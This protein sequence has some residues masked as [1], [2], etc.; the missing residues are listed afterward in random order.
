MV[1]AAA[2]EMIVQCDDGQHLQLT[3][4]DTER[5]GLL[6]DLPA[7]ENLKSSGP[8]PLPFSWQSVNDWREECPEQL[9]MTRLMS[10]VQV[11]ARSALSC[12]A[13]HTLL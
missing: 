7:R 5:S 6:R 13:V 8:V 4:C 2:H 1:S 9:S 3:Q 11:R 10:V 12:A